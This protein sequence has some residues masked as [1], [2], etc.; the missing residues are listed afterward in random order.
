MLHRAHPR[1][2]NILIGLPIH[3]VTLVVFLVLLFATSASLYGQT[4]GTGA[5]S[6]IVTDPSGL[7]VAGADI[8]IANSA[9][10]ESRNTQSNESGHYFVPLLPPGSYAIE[11]TKQGFKLATSSNTRVVVTETTVVDIKL[12]VGAQNESVTVSAQGEQLQ[13]ESVTLGRVTDSVVV[14]NIP[15]V[16]RN[17]TQIIGLNP[18]IA[19]NVNNAAELGRGSGGQSGGFISQGG[20]AT[21]NNFQMDG[22]SVN[23]AQQTPSASAGAPI[24][25]PDT[26]AEFKV[27]TGLYDAASGRNAGANV[28]LVTKS[29]GN[30]LHGSAWEYFRNEALNANEYFNKSLGQP[31]Q[32]LRQNQYG[33]TL[34]GPIKKDKL[35]FFGS[36][37]GTNQRNGMAASCRSTFY[38]PPLTNDRSRAALGA[39]FAGQRGYIQN[40]LGGYGPAILANGS[41]ISPQALALLNAKLPSGEYVIPTPQRINTAKPFDTRGESS[42]SDPCQFDENQ[43]MANGDY[44]QSEKSKFAARYFGAVSDASTTLFYQIP[45]FPLKQPQ[46]FD[47]GSISHTYTFSSRAFNQ[48]QLGFSRTRADFTQDTAFN[49]SDIGVN[50]SASDDPTPWLSIGSLSMGSTSNLRFMQEDW[51]IRD[52]FFLSAG[53]HRFSVGGGYGYGK[54]NMK[55]FT[56]PSMVFALTWA[57]LLLGMNAQQLGTAAIGVPIGNIYGSYDLYGDTSRDWRYHNWDGFG[58]DTY[59][60]ARRLTLTLGLRYEH[61]GNLADAGGRMGNFYVKDANP[62]PPVGGTVAGYVVPSN[63]TGTIPAG[64]NKLDNG[65][66]FE[67]KGADT[68][69][70]RLGFAWL[71]PGGEKV[72]VRGGVGVYHTR[73]VGQMNTQLTTTPPFGIFNQ[74]LG[75]ANGGASIANPFPATQQLPYFVPYSPTSN[76]TL[77]AIA[78][79]FRPPTAYKYSLGVQTQLPADMVFDVSYVGARDLHMVMSTSVN[80]AALASVD[81][82]IRGVTTNTVANVALRKPYQGYTADGMRV[83]DTAGSAWYSALQAMLSRHFASGLQFQASYTWSRMLSTEPGST[84]GT[85][86]SFQSGNQLDKNARYGP[87]PIIRPQRFILTTYYPLPG[88]RNKY[89]ALGRVLGGWDVST[90]MAVQSGQ[91]LTPTLNNPNNAYGISTDRP[92]VVASCALNTG[93]A[94]TSYFSKACFT[95]PPVIGADNRATAFGNAGTGMI[96]GPGQFNIDLSVAKHF[97]VRWPNESSDIQFRTEFFNLTNHPNFGNPNLEYTNALFGTISSTISN[98]RVIQLALRF[99]F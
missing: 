57:D 12:Q 22:L 21:D 30:Q 92:Q 25:N 97:P 20:T 7:L 67:N 33:F 85:N 47:V 9:T 40:V 78:P 54:N 89:S 75:A 16:T 52:T 17:Y 99:T 6:G 35:M 31:K 88:P 5:V 8:K 77:W 43:W 23:D 32:I 84:A 58:Q 14:S 98:P 93:G 90:V 74:L 50:T 19:Q 39:L 79:D 10:G 73:I 66:G 42:I 51:N 60:V 45:G 36:Y 38:T 49:W 68:F 63:F 94:V 27:Q 13:T 95:T 3:I 26:I 59:Q 53:K 80:Q 81:N 46:R 64:V 96:T 86:Y 55:Q 72:L 61:L 11:V 24:P 70:P 56:F 71:L 69:N 83:F 1:Y 4:G 76:L 2:A 65:F 41:N 29:G 82:P 18:G 37:Q 34:G 28:D 91:Q 48:A 62:N 44:L 87:D 15:L